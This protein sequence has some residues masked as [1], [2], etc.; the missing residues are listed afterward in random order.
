MAQFFPILIIAAFIFGI[1]YLVDKGFSKLFRS[2]AQH[3][4]GMAV[5][6]NKRYGVFGVI[7]CVLGILAICVGITDGPVLLW[8]GVIVLGMGIAL[9]VYYLSFGIFYDG[10]SFLLQRFGK[11]DATYSY[12]DILGQKLYLIQG[13]NIVV[14]LHMADGSAVSVQSAFEGVYPFLDTAFA[15]W[16]LQT[17]RDPQSCDFHDPSQSLWFPTV[18]DM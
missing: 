12:K 17:G 2:K 11:K 6:A 5:R 18:E 9:A 3:R 16:C 13:G 10:E 14:E 4:S 15:A 1:C 7:L 8:G